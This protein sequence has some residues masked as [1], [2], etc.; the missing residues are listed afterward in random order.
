MKCRVCQSDNVTWVETTM[1]N[2]DEG[3][4][5][6]SCGDCRSQFQLGIQIAKL[7]Y[8][9]VEHVIPYEIE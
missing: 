6:Y 4:E 8:T 2:E 7:I 5:T 3:Y 9:G 1:L